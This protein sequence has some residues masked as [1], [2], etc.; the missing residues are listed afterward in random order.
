MNHS[1]SV[2][3]RKADIEDIKNIM[4]IEHLAFHS[5]I[6]ESEK[7]FEDRMKAF[8]DGFLVAETKTSG[9]KEIVGYISSELWEESK[10]IPYEN[11]ALN[12]SIFKTHKADGNELYIS[13]VAVDPAVRGNNIGRR[14][15]EELLKMISGKYELKSSIL[16]V[17][18]EWE[19][20]LEMYRKNGFE[21]IAQMPNFFP[22]KEEPGS[23]KIPS[24][25]GIIMRKRF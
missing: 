20:A 11:F 18:T 15:F 19:N 24:G 22:K 2:T 6:I 9:K 17:N 14:L 7:T 13:S 23:R 12:H 25:I 8:G 10:E 3:I 21:E 4:K 1:I 5:E 16:I